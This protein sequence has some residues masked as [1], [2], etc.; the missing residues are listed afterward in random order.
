MLG[1]V[2]ESYYRSGMAAVPVVAVNCI[3]FLLDDI[4]H[5]RRSPESVLAYHK[6]GRLGIVLSQKVKHSPGS[7]RRSII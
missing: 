2:P 6:K 7:F 4:Q 3:L 5:I 1:L